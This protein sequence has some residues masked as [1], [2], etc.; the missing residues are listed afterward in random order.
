[1]TIAIRG[2]ATE[3]D[4]TVATRSPAV[5]KPTGVVDGDLMLMFIVTN[6]AANFASPV[7]GW[8]IIGAEVDAASCSTALYY[9]VASGEGATWTMTNLTAQTEVSDII[10]IAYSGVKT[11]A[12]INAQGTQTETTGTTVSGPSCDPTVNDCMIVQF[13]GTDPGTGAFAGTADTSPAATERWDAK[14]AA[15]DN[16]EYIYIQEWL[17]AGTHA[18]IA[19]DITGLTS[20]GYGHH[21]VALAPNVLTISDGSHTHKSYIDYLGKVLA[22]DSSNVIA[23]WALD[24]AAGATNVNDYSPENNDGTP[25]NVT[26]GSTGIGDDRT[27]A[28]FNGTTSY[29][30]VFSSALATDF[31]GAEGTFSIWAYSANWADSTER[32]LV[33][34]RDAAYN[35]YIYLHKYTTNNISVVRRAAG[36]AD[37]VVSFGVS[38]SGWKHVVGKWSESGDYLK[39]YVNG[40][41]VGTPA[42]SIGTYGNDPTFWDLGAGDSHGVPWNGTLAHA[43]MW[44][45]AISDAQILALYSV[46]LV[47]HESTTPS[48]TIQ[49][50]S[51]T[52]ASSAVALTQHNILVVQNGS[53]T[54][55]SSAVVLIQHNILVTQSGSHTNV[56]TS[57]TLVYHATLTVQNGSHTHTATAPTLIQHNILAAQAGSH[58]HN[59]S[60]VALIQHNILVIQSGS[61]THTSS[62]IALIQHNVLVAQAGSH[63]NVATSPILTQHNI[64]V[65]QAGS[66][67][68]ISSAVIL[69]Q[70][71]ILIAQVGSHTHT[72]DNV[73]LQAGGVPELV[74]QNGSHT[75]TATSPILIQHNI[76]IAQ[77]G[78]HTHTSSAV[79]LIQHNILIAQNGSHTNVSTSPV[80]I[81]HNVLVAQVGSHT[82]AADAP[83]LTQHN[84]LV[85]AD[86]SHTHTS[87]SIILSIAIHLIVANGLH[88]HSAGNVVLTQHNIL[89]AQNGTHTHYADGPALGGEARLK[90]SLGNLFYFGY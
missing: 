7:V 43:A 67:T 54:H 52:H 44:K 45:S 81:Q 63:T 83:A 4:I 30:N 68:H 34:L 59:S 65:V 31:N 15:A 5:T 17:S 60:A 73:I 62:A 19:L 18:A 53:H 6:T 27:S 35:N 70:N 42:S 24:E 46:G 74:I 14:N 47:Y 41:E 57:P 90:R 77:N 82:H 8:T 86:G 75:H 38:G 33:Y 40:S 76:L 16:A 20:A 85:V 39:L 12:P 58:T 64:L 88:T 10:V 25:S 56:A 3:T 29:I 66:H 36:G 2:V 87:S 61:H 28:S 22:T 84:A 11:G 50:G 72:A 71:N 1:M 78:S 48:L 23:E 79:A 69:T 32:T 21:Q 80:L 49:S 26:F 9:K 13:A 55:T 51:H 89:V 37:K